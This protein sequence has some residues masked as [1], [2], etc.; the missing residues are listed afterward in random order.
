MPAWS[1]SPGPPGD[2]D[3]AV[4]AVRSAPR[5]RRRGAPALMGCVNLSRD[6]TYRESIATSTESAIRKG[7]VLAAQGADLVDVGAESS[8][9]KAARVDPQQQ[10]D[11]LVPVVG[12]LA[13]TASSSLPRPM[14][15]SWR[16]RVSRPAPGP[17][18][19]R[20][21][22]PG[23]GLRPRRGVR[24]D[25]GA[26]LRAGCATS[27]TSAMSTWTSTRSPGCSTT[28]QAR[29]AAARAA[30]VDRLVIDP[31]MGFYYGN[32]VDPQTRLRHQSRV[33][34]STF[35]LRRLG[36]RSATRCRT[37]STCSRTSSASAEGSSP[38]WRCWEGR[39]CCAR[40]R[41]RRCA[42]SSGPC[43]R[44][45][46]DRRPGLLQGPNQRQGGPMPTPSKVTRPPS[47][48]S[49]RQPRPDPCARRAREQPQGRHRRLP[50]APADGVHRCLRFRARARW[51]STPSP[52]SRSG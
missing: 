49:R 32:L 37:R 23:R 7:R 40:T 34:T 44:S 51:C 31:G 30:G 22:A 20:G 35:R 15:R 38:C 4:R 12:A 27:A 46:C 29:V 25:R 16:G 2:L 33:I 21:G 43:G 24:R 19:H 14:T 5:L 17:E 47:P 52:P 10:I 1:S 42:R 28:S 45:R 6:S 48:A 8:T 41:C 13:A 26:V 39:A 11:A 50:E 36:F 18:L 9:A 3:R